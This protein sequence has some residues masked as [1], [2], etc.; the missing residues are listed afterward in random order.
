MNQKKLVVWIHG[1]GGSG[2]TTQSR[3]LLDTLGCN[4]EEPIIID[5][6]KVKYT[7]YGKTGVCIL[8][9][10]GKNQ[11]TGLDTVYGKLGSDGITTTLEGALSDE[12]V[13][14]III[15]CILASA[16]WYEKWIKAGLRDRFILLSI[17]LDF[18]LWQNFKRISE[19]RAKKSGKNWWEEELPDTVYKN[20]GTKN[21]ETRTIF[22]KIAGKHPK[23]PFDVL[24]DKSI[25]LDALE[26]KIE[27]HHKI[28]EAIEL[29]C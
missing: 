1:S 18:S 27:I 25:R 26:D 23:M 22:D 17:H 7:V 15:E 2:K 5:E 21:F 28:I 8:G 29:I 4:N 19:R 16:K 9:K 20:V 24:A 14:L 3:L 6:E 10:M 11:C 13:S 12:R